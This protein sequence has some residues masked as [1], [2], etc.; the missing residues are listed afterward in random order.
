MVSLTTPAEIQRVNCEV[1]VRLVQFARKA[2]R[3]AFI[4]KKGA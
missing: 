4:N 1:T 3:E 2:G